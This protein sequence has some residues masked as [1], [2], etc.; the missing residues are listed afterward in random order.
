MTIPQIKDYEKAIGT[1]IP[2]KM[3][4]NAGYPDSVKDEELLDL[5]LRCA[6]SDMEMVVD[7][8]DAENYGVD[9]AIVV[10]KAK[11]YLRKY[12]KA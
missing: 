4:I 3:H 6:I 9:T 10:R 1:L 5:P 2:L 12:K 7:N 8:E 11:W